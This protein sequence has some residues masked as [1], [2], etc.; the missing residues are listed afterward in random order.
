MATYGN[1]RKPALKVRRRRLRLA[2]AAGFPRN[3]HRAT[4]VAEQFVQEKLL[5]LA[6]FPPAGRIELRIVGA[7]DVN[8]DTRR[9]ARAQK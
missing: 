5:P 9:E 8:A 2:V 3:S 6:R 1:D 4:S 7:A